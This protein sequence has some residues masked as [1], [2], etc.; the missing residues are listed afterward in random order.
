MRLHV[1]DLLVDFFAEV[2]V[3][4]VCSLDTEAEAQ[5]LL[6]GKP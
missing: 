2:L 5:H 4:G 6:A 1:D 3:E